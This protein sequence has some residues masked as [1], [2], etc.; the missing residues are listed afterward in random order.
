MFENQKNLFKQPDSNIS[1]QLMLRQKTT[2]LNLS[3]VVVEMDIYSEIRNRY[4]NGESV[5]SIARNLEISRQTV[6]K[7]C[8]GSTHPDVRKDDQRKPDIIT[9]SITAFILNCFQEDEDRKP[10]KATTHS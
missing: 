3:F 2:N 5:R 9:S 6:K 4:S 10:E 1:T 8:E 7:Y